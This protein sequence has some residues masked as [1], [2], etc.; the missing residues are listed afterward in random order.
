MQRERTDIVTKEWPWKKIEL[1][2]TRMAFTKDPQY[3]S[4]MDQE[5][6]Q[7]KKVESWDRKG[8]R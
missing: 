7:R 5:R 2:H 1:G 6:L 8:N 3:G 4:H